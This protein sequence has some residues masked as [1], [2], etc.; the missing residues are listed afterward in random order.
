M[1][2]APTPTA[3]LEL[4]I[5]DR[6]GLAHLHCGTPLIQTLRIHRAG[7]PPLDECSLELRVEPA[8]GEPLRLPASALQSEPPPLPLDAARLT[9]IREPVP[10]IL[11][12]ALQ[13]GERVVADTRREFTVLPATEWC[14]G[15]AQPELLA[16]FCQPSHPA[17][18]TLLADVEL[19]APAYVQGDP[20]HSRARARTL[21]DA[22]A[23]AKVLRAA[24]DPDPLQPQAL[25]SAGQILAAGNASTAELATLCAALLERAGLHPLLVVQRNGILLGSWLSAETFRAAVVP[26]GLVLKKRLDLDLIE[27][28]TPQALF[29][30]AGAD[31]DAAVTAGRRAAR[32][33][34]AHEFTLDLRR[35][36]ALDIAPLPAAAFDEEEYPEQPSVAGTATTQPA[37]AANAAS[38]EP[39]SA[40]AAQAT[41][42]SRLDLWQHRL[43]DLSLRNRLLN[44]RETL[45]TVP[46]LCQHLAALEDALAQ[47]R[48]FR[49]AGRP[50]L[51]TTHTDALQQALDDALEQGV[52][53]TDLAEDAVEPR[54][55]KLQREARSSFEEGGANLLYLALGFLTWYEAPASQQPRRAPLLLLPLDLLRPSRRSG[56][57]VRLSG[58]EP[59]VN[60]TLLE[61]LRNDFGLDVGG[62]ETPAED[63]T[64]IDV[65]DIVRRVRQAVL[66]FDRWDVEETAAIGL[67]SFTKFLMW[68]DLQEHREL[69]SRSRVMRH[70]VE[71]PAEPFEPDAVFPEPD[72]LDARSPAETYCPLNTDSSQLA[73]VFAAAEGRSFV[74][75]GPPGTGK[76]QTITNLIAHCLAEGQRVLF[77]SEKMAALHVVRRRLERVGLGPFCLEL[78]S[79]RAKKKQVLAQ[80]EEALEIGGLREPEEWQSQAD[81]LLAARQTLN[82]YCETLR[83]RRPAGV[84]AFAGL[85]AAIGHRGAATVRL[86]LGTE[87]AVDATRRAQLD[88]AAEQLELAARGIGA[89]PG[90]AF[91]HCG[92]DDWDR[93][94][95]RRLEDTAARLTERA[96]A[97]EQDGDRLLENLGASAEPPSRAGL[98]A[99]LA[100]AEEI[101]GGQAGQ[102]ALLEDAARA[103]LA[104]ALGR[105]IEAGGRRDAARTA[106]GAIYDRGL[107][108]LDL[109][110]LAARLA[111]ADSAWFPLSW[112]RRRPV[113]KALRGV[114]RAPQLPHRGELAQQL[115]QART[116]RD[117][118]RACEAAHSMLQRAFGERAAEATP[119]WPA[120]STELAWA[121]R[122]A[123]AAAILQQNTGVPP[124]T[125]LRLAVAG[126]DRQA[127]LP[128][129]Q[130]ATRTCRTTL[131]AFDECRSEATTLLALDDAA[132]GAPEQTGYAGRAAAI[133]GRW[134]EQRGA[135]RPWTAYV[136]ARDA[137][138]ALDLQPLV[139]ALATGSCAP[140]DVAARYAASFW[141]W[142]VGAL[143][144][145]EPE[146]RRFQGHLHAHAIEQFRDLDAALTTLAQQMV[147]ARLAA[148]MPRTAGG[149]A[150]AGSEVGVLQRQLKKQRGHWPIRVLLRSLPHLLPRLKP[151]FL[152]SPLSV[153]QYLSSDIPPFDLV[154][155]DEASQI[156]VWDAIGAIGRGARLVVVGDSKQLP[157]TTFFH[158]AEQD[159]DVEIDEEMVEE[160]ESILD[161]CIAAQLPTR[162]LRWHYRSRHESLIAFSNYHYYGNR[163]FT[164]PSPADR[165]ARMGVRWRP[166]D[167]VY[168]RSK[169]RTNRAEAEAVL[170]EIRSRIAAGDQRSIG[171]VTFSRPQQTLIEDLLDEARGEDAALDTHLAQE[172]DEPL[173][174]KNLE[175]V[176]GD[177]RDVILFSVCY[178][179]DARGRVYMNF[180]PLNQPGGER[181][182]NVA[183]TRAKQQVLV[184]STLQ[185]EQIDLTRVSSTAVGVRHL[186][187]FLE[188]AR[189]GPEALGTSSAAHAGA[190]WD[191]PFER[192]VHEVLEEHGHT[193]HNQVGCSGYRIDLAVTAPDAPGHYVL[194]IEC[195]GAT[196]HSTASAR[197]RDRIRQSVLESLGWS[198]H[199]IWSTDWLF[200]RDAEVRRLL[201]AVEDA[202]ARRAAAE[203]AQQPD[204]PAPQP[205][206]AEPEAPPPAI[207]EG[208]APAR[209][210]PALYDEVELPAIAD[211]E[212]LYDETHEAAARE[213]VATLVASE[214]PV[215]L[216]VVLRRLAGAF[217][218]QRVT[219]KARARLQALVD[220]AGADKELLAD[221]RAFLWSAGS[222][223][224]IA[225]YRVPGDEGRGERDIDD[226]HPA[227]IAHAAAEVLALGISLGRE[228]LVRDTARRFGAKRVGRQIEESVS[229]A[230]DLLVAEGRARLDGERVVLPD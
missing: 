114:L 73:A 45:R 39:A 136:R 8:L 202:L 142:W 26:E 220:G 50:A 223:R 31:F 129:L 186:K 86:E 63:D 22:L 229:T 70:L 106:L 148:R 188:Y 92:L 56:F 212:G 18:D 225:G 34:D 19:D 190:D 219:A 181:R 2:S 175:N 13:R 150:S 227:E 199:R 117:D 122:T 166:I 128:D 71:R 36:R 132:F 102:A 192:D 137:A 165:D 228:D 191:S 17:L 119:D 120:F 27:V 5:S 160:L 25:R 47:D 105:A 3:P 67:F 141:D 11:S 164:F 54:L 177:E 116:W 113:V 43:L 139:D 124:A 91:E 68:R 157:P 171:V 111:R 218:V 214:S 35:A 97:L 144:D 213:A 104:A 87:D 52:L 194:G 201:G 103:D 162:D 176:Q 88:A 38:A 46:L 9:T 84:S 215:A 230:I 224:R 51:A 69:L 195:D 183:I 187:A 48:V 133:A 60:I 121:Q 206:E 76:S 59:R 82:A 146:L 174:V 80:L 89:V 81:R 169:T 99:A 180:G 163:L 57:S 16:A 53:H 193:V 135:L 64:G 42:A 12:A 221:G 207:D 95:E 15:A 226:I 159:E 179:P 173:F 40:P 77:V 145:A 172:V 74:L 83:A 196:Y 90:H 143:L 28:W 134:L 66:P 1:P 205:K 96:R 123:A 155:F 149:T 167:G 140:A 178:G 110:A 216:E 204:A 127:A 222:H 154:V 94:L 118:E 112:W 107:L 184:F 203:P 30:D 209:A 161:E 211:D 10:A 147:S 138:A 109:E 29:A 62:L 198:L 115:Q 78:H 208:S 44:H 49:L 14:G 79:N 200:D 33:L 98:E 20:E 24:D 101:A 21:L 37:L 168:D 210:T 55:I 58:E 217:D 152:M 182:L 153:A 72:T 185:P 197:D 4:A 108:D 65:E 189:L 156:P 6:A 151:C 130:R 61:K 75:Q 126:A 170:T 158:R 32:D 23:A 93:G 7:L 131:E 41:P 125:S 100:L 85:S